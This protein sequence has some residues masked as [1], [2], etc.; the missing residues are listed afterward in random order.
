[1]I[2]RSIDGE[3]LPKQWQPYVEK[4]EQRI[5]ELERKLLILGD[6]AGCAERDG[7]IAE[8]EKENDGLK[9]NDDYYCSV[10]LRERA[11]RAEATL[12]EV[13]ELPEL[14]LCRMRHENMSL[15]DEAMDVA[16]RTAADELRAILGKYVPES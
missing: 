11:E 12:R 13:G 6:C 14:W 1:M 16:F 9:D 5:E 3:L 10:R 15:T 7:R 8:L 2:E 4:L